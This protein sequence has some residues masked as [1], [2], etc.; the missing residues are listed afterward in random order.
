MAQQFLDY[1]G[2]EKVW[3]KIKTYVA[4][5]IA[6]SQDGAVLKTGDH[7][8]AGKLTV[9]G[10]IAGNLTGNVTGKAD[11]AGVSDQTKASLTIKHENG[12]TTT[13]N[14]SVEETLDLSDLATDTQLS[15][16]IEGLGAEIDARIASVS[17]DGILIST[18]TT[19][20]KAVTVG[21]TTKLTN[22][23]AVAETALQKADIT[24]GSS[25]GTINVDGTDVAVKG[26]GSAAYTESSAYASASAFNT[27]NTTVSE[28]T[29][30]ITNLKNQVTGLTAA[31]QFKG[32]VTFDPTSS[33]N[34]GGGTVSTSIPATVTI[35]GAT[36]IHG[37]I[38]IYGAKEYVWDGNQKKWVELGDTTAESTAIAQLNEWK[39]TASSQIS[40]NTDN[41]SANTTAINALKNGTGT[42]SSFGGKTGAITVRSGSTATAAVNFT[43]DGNQLQGTVYG[44]ATAA[45]GSKADSAIQTVN[46][47]S[48]D[49]GD[50]SVTGYVNVSTSGTTRTVSVKV[51]TDSSIA[52]GETTI[53]TSGAVYT[54][55]AGV[56]NGLDSTASASTASI[57]K[58]VTATSQTN[59]KVS[60][61]TTDFSALTETD[62]NTI[63]V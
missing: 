43:M 60:V 49:P 52:S 22:A 11:T 41:I 23:V 1:A 16:A 14:G 25:N 36:Y 63:C 47:S 12:T 7:T 59:G 18:S 42:V 27:L 5:Y 50:A 31:T 57:A 32:V 62:I 44:V 26:L 34:T 51:P 58:V 15:A 2:L 24:T 35:S 9:Q 53:P 6:S 30:D 38:V 56:I 17:G 29:I 45:Q 19:D 37:D 21:P 20:T 46:G 61:T 3:A 54:Y 13:Y 55:V 39:G 28:H 33:S 48:T 10:G 40:T 4:T 8:M